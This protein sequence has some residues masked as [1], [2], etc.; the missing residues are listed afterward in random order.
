M[1][2]DLADLIAAEE[3]AKK[4]YEELMAAKTKEVEELTK[5]IEEKLTRIGE[6]GVE[7][8][9]MKEGLDDTMKALMEDKKFLE[10][11]KK[12]CASKEAD[13]AIRSKTRSE[14]LLAIAETIKILND[15][16]ALELFKKTLPS[17]SL[18]QV[19]VAAREIRARALASLNGGR[20]AADPRLDFIALAIRGKKV[21]FE[22][23][24][25]MIDEMV[26][27]LG[28]E[29]VD[30]DEKLAYCEAELDKAEDNLKELEHT[31]GDL[32]TAIEEGK[33]ALATVTEEIEALV[34]GIKDL[35]KQVAEATEQRKEENEDFVEELAANTAAK[36][37]LGLAKNRMNKIYN[38]KLYKA[39]P[40]RELSAED[41]ITVNMGGTLAPTQPPGGIAGTGVAA[42]SQVAP[43]PPPETYGAYQKKG[44]ESSGVIAMMDLLLKDLAKQI[45]ELETG[46][47]LAQEDYEKFMADSAEKRATDTQAIVDKSAAKADLETDLQMNGE[48][49]KAKQSEAMATMEQI[50]GLHLE[51][52]WLTKNYDIRK[53][54]RAGEIDALKKAKAVLSGADYSLVQTGAHA[55]PI[56][57]L[58]AA[59]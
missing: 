24:I 27:L 51:C 2:R 8:V 6:L 19:S 10:D 5:M 33:A 37:L 39:P 15:D 1:L 3:E 53:E 49:L 30:D 20:K 44:E 12:N 43:P 54:A 47:K 17:P 36:Q 26:A 22:K 9:N 45:T 11:L 35:D 16:D 25:Q 48:E 38:P 56:R 28:K 59:A 34:Q 31:I 41:R 52:D 46:E 18:L 57:L 7:I 32:T 23:V 55:R 50:K 13:W 42:L 4:I 21:S 58:R 40:K 14:E 29:Q